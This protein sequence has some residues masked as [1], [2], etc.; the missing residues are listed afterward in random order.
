[1][2]E[3]ATTSPQEPAAAA[4]N[5]SNC[6]TPLLGPHCYR[7]GQPVK[8]LVRPLSGWLADLLDTA[9]NW[10]G[11]LPRTLVPLLFRPG[12][13]TREYLAGRRV[14][15]V[16]PVR[17]F[18]VLAIVLFLAVGLYGNLELGGGAVSAGSL[19]PESGD[20]ARVEALVAWL[21]D[22]TRA[23]VLDEALRPPPAP[24]DVGALQIGGWRDGD[25]VRLSWL[26]DALNEQLQ[27]ALERIARNA[28]RINE[29]PGPFLRELLSAAPTTLFFMLPVFALVL[30]LVYLFKRRLYAE[31]LLVALHSH[32][33]IALALLLA[34]ALSALGGVWAD[35]PVLPTLARSLAIALLVWI[36]V[37]LLL[38]QKRVYGQGWPLTL[39]KFLFVGIVYQVLLVLGL[40]L[41][42]LLSLL[43]W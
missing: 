23:E 22:T 4:G 11:R 33:F 19:G 21:P 39:L 6:Q 32:S 18:L 31:H 5:C 8:G 25:P 26:P 3:T 38:T 34:M 35:L 7:C 15:Y 14:R 2:G 41:T 17:L 37:N 13:L 29:D 30:K 20:R 9:L 36:P 24:A 12:H 40:L 10:D 42:V 43:L 1:M 28:R 27:S 16:T